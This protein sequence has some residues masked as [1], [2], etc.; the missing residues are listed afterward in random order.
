MYDFSEGLDGGLL[1]DLS[2]LPPDQCFA[3]FWSPDGKYM[4][5]AGAGM[6]E[7]LVYEINL[8]NIVTPFNPLGQIILKTFEEV[9]NFTSL[10]I[11][12][13]GQEIVK[14]AV[15]YVGLLL[16]L[17]RRI[18]VGHTPITMGRVLSTVGGASDSGQYLGEIIR[19]QTF[20]TSVNLQNLTPAWYRTNLHPYF[21]LSPRV[22]TFWAWRPE[23][24]PEEVAYAWLTN[25]PRPVNQ[26]P[27]GMMEVQFDLEGLT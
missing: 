11:T 12:I 17:E 22:P 10:V 3:V 9:D 7:L 5:V 21:S 23:T 16:E 20:T 13:T 1:P 4:A 19:R 15:L 26:R 14:M 27:N 8:V 2:T 24:Y 18:Y 25:Q 6:A